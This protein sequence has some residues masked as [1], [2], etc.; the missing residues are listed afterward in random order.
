MLHIFS[1]DYGEYEPM[2][3]IVPAL[4]NLIRRIEE[5]ERMK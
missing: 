2:S 3:M 4:K 1:D 5:N